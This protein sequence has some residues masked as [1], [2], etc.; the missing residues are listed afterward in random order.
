VII[1]YSL[2]IIHYSL[3]I[4]HYSLERRIQEQQPEMQDLPSNLCDLQQET[5]HGKQCWVLKS[6]GKAPLPPQVWRKLTKIPL[7]VPQIWGI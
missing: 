7:K 5:N 4:I 6:V 3:F 1:H 2:F